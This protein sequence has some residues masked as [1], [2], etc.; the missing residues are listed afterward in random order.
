MIERRASR[1]GQQ[2]VYASWA[3]VVVVLASRPAA[4]TTDDELPE[5]FRAGTLEIIDP[6]AKSAIGDTHEAKVFFEFRNHAAAADRLT[7]VRTTIASGPNQLREVAQTA[8]PTHWRVVQA[9]ELPVEPADGVPFELSEHGYYIVL[10]GLTVPLTMG[11]QFPLELEFRHAGR[12]TVNV[13]SRFHSP[14][15]IRRIRAAAARGDIEALKQLGA[16]P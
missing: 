9:I 10:S 12:V 14:K 3:L 8:Q 13:T 11:K 4:A 7:T 2:L 1:R 15:L 6:W 5:I 16:G